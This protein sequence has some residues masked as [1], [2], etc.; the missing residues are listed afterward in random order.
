MPESSVTA[1][2]NHWDASHATRSAERDPTGT[3]Y[4]YSHVW[5][6]LPFYCGEGVPLVHKYPVFDDWSVPG[7]GPP[8]RPAARPA[9]RVSVTASWDEGSMPVSL[10]NTSH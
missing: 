4:A 5:Q 8:S 3:R 7:R 2:R 10:Q 1:E 9:V 6:L